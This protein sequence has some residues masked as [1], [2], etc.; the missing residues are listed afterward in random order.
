MRYFILILLSIAFLGCSGEHM[1]HNITKTQI[2]MSGNKPPKSFEFANLETM[3]DYVFQTKDFSFSLPS[4]KKKD[5]TVMGGWVG[6]S[7]RN[8]KMIIIGL[9]NTITYHISIS[10]Y[11]DKY[12]MKE[13]ELEMGTRKYPNKREHSNGIP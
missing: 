5:Y 10:I 6:E 7:M 12:T 3:R 11:S 4:A 2:A 1:A 13:K 9:K 8:D